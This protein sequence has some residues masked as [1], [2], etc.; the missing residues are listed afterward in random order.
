MLSQVSTKINEISGIQTS[1]EVKKKDLIENTNTIKREMG[2][3]IED[4]II[5]LKRKEKELL[6][7]ADTFLQE[8]INEINTYTRIL[9]SKIIA[10]NKLIDTVNSN[11]VRKDEVNYC[12][13]E[14]RLIYSTS[15]LKIIKRYR[16]TLFQIFQ[17]SLILI[18]SKT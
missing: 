8:N 1:L 13:I 17:K 7:R 6:E 2:G 4:I 14:Y 15:S 18:V 5:K 16:K 10:L 9:Q 3:A 11:M 12:K